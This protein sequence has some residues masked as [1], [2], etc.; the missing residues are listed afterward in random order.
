MHRL[1]LSLQFRDGILREIKLTVGAK[2]GRRKGDERAWK[3]LIL[4]FFIVKSPVFERLDYVGISNL[5][6]ERRRQL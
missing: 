2:N 5:E 6:C 3:S 1:G 4:Q